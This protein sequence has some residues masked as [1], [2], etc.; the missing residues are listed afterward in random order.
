MSRI[1]HSGACQRRM[2][3]SARK[4]NNL[5]RES[6]KTHRAMSSVPVPD[7][8]GL[9]LPDPTAIRVFPLLASHLQLDLSLTR[10]RSLHCSQSRR[11]SLP[12]PN[13]YLA[14]RAGIFRQQPSVDAL[15]VEVMGARSTAD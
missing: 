13:C 12:R 4:T 1:S 3:D 6:R 15:R 14:E 9:P 5:A 10:R 8:V 7:G 2:Y 11:L